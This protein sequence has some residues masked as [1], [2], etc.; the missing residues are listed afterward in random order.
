[1]T[2]AWIVDALGEQGFEQ[3]AARIPGSELQS[4]LLEVMRRRA[5]TRTSHDVLAQ[6]RRDR[7]VRPA[8][9]DQRESIEIDRHLLA[10]ADGFAAIELSPVTPLGTSSTMGPTDQHKVLSAL[11]ATEVVSDPTNVLALEC[12]ERLRAAPATP[13]HFATS[14]RVIRAQAVPDKPG[15]AAHFRI[16]CLASAGRESKDHGFAVEM[17]TRHI[18]TMQRALDRLE[19]HGY[20]FGARRLDILATPERS[21]LADRV[22]TAVGGERKLLDH[23]YY[24]GGVRY[25]LWVTHASGEQVPLIDGGLFDWVA[26]LTTN[27]RNVY[28]TTGM[29]AQLVAYAFRAS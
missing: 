28:V 17:L 23:A 18:T 27:A 24:N 13:V 5:S 10:V 16:F 25:M 2:R 29:G 26:K 11:R 19:Q 14:Q 1:M 21:V 12:A 22:A 6:Y 3:L 9:I 4:L 20:R 8:A 15:Y 7:F